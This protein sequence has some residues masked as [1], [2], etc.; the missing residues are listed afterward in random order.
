MLR[1]FVIVCSAMTAGAA[2][3]QNLVVNPSAEEAAE[4]GMPVGWGLYIGAGGAKLT[5]S[6]EEKHSGE[7]SACLELTKWYTPKDAEDTAENH[8]VSAGIVL[9]ESSFYGPEGALEAV[10]GG[11]YVFSFWYKGDIKS[12]RVVARGWPAGEDDEVKPVG[13][14][15]TGGTLRPGNA[16]QRATGT[17]RVA[18]S[19]TRFALMIQ[20]HGKEKKGFALGKLYADDAEILPKAYPDGE[21]RAVW[22]GSVRAKERDEGLREIAESLDKL[23]AAGFNTIFATVTTLYMAALDAPEPEKLDPR[24]AWDAFGEVIKA[25]DERGIQ[26]HAW[27]SPWIYK[28]AYRAVELRDHPEWAAV[29][30]EGVA[31]EGGV[32]LVRPEVRQFELDFVAAVIDRYPGL[33]G[34]HVEE[35][36]FPWGDYCYCDYCQQLCREW[37]GIDIREDPEAARPVVRNLAA[38]MS[39]D[40]F[41]RLRKLMMDKRPEMWL[42]ANGSGGANPDWYIGRDW[43][44]WARRGYIDFYV[45]QLYTKDVA[46]LA[47]RAL[48]TKEYLG[49]CDL[50]TGMAITWSGIYPERQDPE[51]IKA[52]IRAAREVGSKGFVLFHRYHF[53]D[54]HFGAVREAIDERAG[55]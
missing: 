21:M 49:R 44:T 37:F 15:V 32:C 13:L 35:P 47:Q 5:V 11:T 50:V 33:V 22:W 26:V 31:T 3:A 41:A 4:N 45:P 43:T 51:V 28:H 2:L 38:F 25:A 9:A 30:S 1:A 17:F 46:S 27:V 36:G 39:T 52:E 10:P 54:E 34:I 23:K 53:Y 14:P 6:T 29:N 8:S 18:A 24:A 40:Y 20:T 16:W 12:G 19:T 55:Q 48:E 42:S 7:G